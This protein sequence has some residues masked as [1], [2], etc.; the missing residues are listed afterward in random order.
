M[1]FHV[2]WA[3]R[4]IVALHGFTLLQCFTKWYIVDKDITYH[5]IGTSTK[6]VAN[7]QQ[8]ERTGE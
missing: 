8:L 5:Q 6:F 3:L 7:G 1:C 2:M 4:K